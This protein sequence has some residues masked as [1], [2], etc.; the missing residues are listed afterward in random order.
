MLARVGKDEFPGTVCFHGPFALIDH[1]RDKTC[2]FFYDSEGFNSDASSNKRVKSAC[3]MVLGK[4]A[5]GDSLQHKGKERP[6]NQYDST[7]KFEGADLVVV[8]A[9]AEKQDAIQN[10]IHFEN[11]LRSKFIRVMLVVTHAEGREQAIKEELAV[12]NDE[13]MMVN[14]YKMFYNAD[15]HQYEAPRPDPVKDLQFLQLYGRMLFAIE[16]TVVVPNKKSAL[17]R[18]WKSC[19]GLILRNV[20]MMTMMA[21]LLVIVA[22]FIYQK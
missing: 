17:S 8:V 16:S 2:A 22:L 1:E 5:A 10:A 18:T 13:W 15:F 12:T 11:R 4:V 19:S 7:T 21:A 3:K 6:V 9:S 14:N 20:Q